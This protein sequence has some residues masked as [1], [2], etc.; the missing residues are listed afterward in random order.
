MSRLQSYQRPIQV[1]VIEDDDLR[2]QSYERPRQVIVIEDDDLDASQNPDIEHS[3]NFDDQSD[4]V[5]SQKD[6]NL[7]D[8]AFECPIC[9]EIPFPPLEIHSCINGHS[10]CS[11]CLSK[12]TENFE[13]Y[14]TCPTCKI[15]LQVKENGKLKLNTIRNRYFESLIL[16]YLKK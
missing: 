11:S 9:F 1:I 14:S 15:S 13:L 8:T 3:G 2:L 16:T 12:L 6:F 10:L 5:T 7:P 4:N